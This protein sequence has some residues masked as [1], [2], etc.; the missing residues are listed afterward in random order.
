MLE[1]IVYSWVT[2][3]WDNGFAVS[4][5][6]I[7][8]KALQLEPQFKGGCNKKL[9]SW[10]RKFRKRHDL[11]FRRPTRVSQY[12]PQQAEAVRTEFAQSTM[13]MVH[14][15][16]IPRNMFVNMDETAVYFDTDYNYTVNK[17]G[18][19]TVSVRHG[20]SDNKRC[21]V[22]VTVAADGTKLLS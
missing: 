11:V 14:M 16:S 5:A 15:N 6:N 10:A 21:T 9:R 3:Q 18:A 2:N 19:K 8:C 13:T 7:I 1:S 22:C 20:S 4:T 17:K 12:S